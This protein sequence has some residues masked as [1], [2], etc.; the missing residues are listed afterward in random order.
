[1]GWGFIGDIAGGL[2]GSIED[3]GDYVKSGGKYVYRTVVEDNG[4][5]L[6]SKGKKSPIDYLAKETGC[7]KNKVGDHLQEFALAYVKG[8]G[9]QEKLVMKWATECALLTAA[10]VEYKPKGLKGQEFGM[11]FAIPN[12]GNLTCDKGIAAYNALAALA[13]AGG[14]DLPELDPDIIAAC[15]QAGVIVDT[16]KG[17][18]TAV[19]SLT[20]NTNQGGR[21]KAGGTG[22]AAENVDSTGHKWIIIRGSFD[23]GGISDYA[24]TIGEMPC[25]WDT[26]GGRCGNGTNGIPLYGLTRAQVIKLNVGVSEIIRELPT[27]DQQLAEYARLAWKGLRALGI[28]PDQIEPY[29][30]PVPAGLEYLAT[31][32]P[33]DRQPG[34]DNTNQGKGNDP[35]SVGGKGG[36]TDNGWSP[37]QIGL[38]V[39][40]GLVALGIAAKLMAGGK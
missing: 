9:A 2:A 4:D 15:K 36:P 35:Y 26:P 28:P 6:K 32:Q 10:G 19:N 1:M 29:Y 3:A 25:Q 8:N 14:Y 37:L 16:T 23:K 27:R 21:A 30:G 24:P 5:P 13:S 39:G 18:I 11:S 38:A 31:P 12:T 7:V 22:M 40:G 17:V 33:G 34:S 20:S